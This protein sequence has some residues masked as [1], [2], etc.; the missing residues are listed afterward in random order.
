M[1]I[2]FLAKNGWKIWGIYLLITVLFS[3]VVYLGKIYNPIIS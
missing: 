2:A 1:I 3:I